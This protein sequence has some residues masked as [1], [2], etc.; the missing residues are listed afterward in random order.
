MSNC[1]KLWRQLTS[2]PILVG[3]P[4]CGN[5]HKD[6]FPKDGEVNFPKDGL[7]EIRSLFGDGYPKGLE[8]GNRLLK[9]IENNEPLESFRSPVFSLDEDNGE[10]VGFGAAFGIAPYANAEPHMPLSETALVLKER[11]KKFAF[12][13]PV[14]SKPYELLPEELPFMKTRLPAVRFVLLAEDIQPFQG[15]FHPSNDTWVPR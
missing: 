6:T 13:S 11:Y 1:E 2:G 10:A 4:L 7:D 9:V 3:D 8:I 12:I 14:I 15:N 5:A